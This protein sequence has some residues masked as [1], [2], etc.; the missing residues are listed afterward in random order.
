MKSLVSLLSSTASKLHIH[1]V[2]G[3]TEGVCS[4]QPHRY[5]DEEY[6]LLMDVPAKQE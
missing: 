3:L 2:G 4:M 1:K 6:G 5:G